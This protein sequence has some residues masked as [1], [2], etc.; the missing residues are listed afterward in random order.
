MWQYLIYARMG[1]FYSF[2]SFGTV[3]IL[4]RHVQSSLAF[5]V[6]SCIYWRR[7]RSLP[8]H[9]FPSGFGSSEDQSAKKIK[10]KSNF[11]LISQSGLTSRG[12]ALSRLRVSL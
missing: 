11:F 9:P 12:M 10:T 8:C 6:I 5:I 1:L 2:Q 3:T 4:D 7:S